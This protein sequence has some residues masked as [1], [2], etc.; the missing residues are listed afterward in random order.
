MADT[1]DVVLRVS[2]NKEKGYVKRVAGAIAWQLRE[3]GFCRVRAVKV[4]A[5]NTATKAIAIV[6]QR[7]SRAGLKFAIDMVFSPTDADGDHSSTAIEMTVQDTESTQPEEFVEYKVS[8]KKTSEDIISKL[9]SAISIQVR[10]GKGVNLRCIGPYAVS[11]AITACCVSKGN[12]YTN[13][14]NAIVIPSWDSLP[15]TEKG[16]PPISLLQISFWGE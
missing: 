6:N 15:S 4:D 12:I 11:R 8:G 2:A 7:V 10:N 14:L 13:G 9:S 1:N 16:K 5:I 3:K